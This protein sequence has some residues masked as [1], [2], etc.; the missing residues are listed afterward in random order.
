MWIFNLLPTPLR[1]YAGVMLAASLF[2]A[3]WYTHAVYSGYVA[4]EISEQT[5]ADLAEGQTNIV[6]FN[7]DFDKGILYVEDDCVSQPIPNS[8]RVLLT[9]K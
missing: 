1:V 4:N 8:L 2:F 5:V 7:Q 6:N 3:G 9:T